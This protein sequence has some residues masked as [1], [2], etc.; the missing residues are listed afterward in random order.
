MGVEMTL[1]EGDFVYTDKGIEQVHWCE[2]N[3][4][5]ELVTPKGFMLGDVP[6]FEENRE[7]EINVIGYEM[8][9][10]WNEEAQKVLRKAKGMLTIYKTNLDKQSTYSEQEVKDVILKIEEFC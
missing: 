2:V 7:K 4:E 6:S 1:K 8:V 9:R 3:G 5:K 10:N